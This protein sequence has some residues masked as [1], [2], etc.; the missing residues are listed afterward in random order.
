MEKKNSAS[1]FWARRPPSVVYLKT[2]TWLKVPFSCPLSGQKRGQHKGVKRERPATLLAS[3]HASW[4]SGARKA[5]AHEQEIKWF[6]P[7]VEILVRIFI[8]L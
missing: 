2:M 8:G 3:M 5:R 4:E 1:L 7:Q 6:R